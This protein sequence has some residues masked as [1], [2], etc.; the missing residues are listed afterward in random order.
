MQGEDGTE[1]K[2]E[3]E[4]EEEEEEEE[5]KDEED[6]W[7]GFESA[8][9]PP[10]SSLPSSLPS[11]ASSSLLITPEQEPLLAEALKIVVLAFTHLPS[12]PSSLPIHQTRQLSLLLPLLAALLPA[13]PPS[14]SL[15]PPLVGQALLGMAKQAPLPFKEAVQALPPSATSALEVSLR[16]AATTGAAAASSSGSCDGRRGGGGGEGGERG[17]GRA[18]GGLKIDMSRYQ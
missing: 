9:P 8:P 5:E 14:L 11:S 4:E 12:P 17:R 16:S 18:G 7:A 13:L 6:D 1:G 15:L 2:E 10:P 3:K